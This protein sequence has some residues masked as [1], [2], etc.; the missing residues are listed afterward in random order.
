MVRGDT[1]EFENN[2]P[3]KHNA[4]HLQKQKKIEIQVIFKICYTKEL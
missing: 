4:K 2:D 3:T 1:A